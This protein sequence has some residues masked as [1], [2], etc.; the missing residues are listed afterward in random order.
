MTG[1]A[2]R[3]KGAAVSWWI[4]GME[5]WIMVRTVYHTL[6]TARPRLHYKTAAFQ[7][8]FQKVISICKI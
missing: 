3:V 1:M 6:L 7:G 2:I 8:R 5:N 4:D